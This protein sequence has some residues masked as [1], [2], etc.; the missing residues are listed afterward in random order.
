MRGTGRMGARTA[1][2]TGVSP[3]TTPAAIT[4]PSSAVKRL[5]VAEIAERCKDGRCFHYD[6]PFTNG[7]K[8]VC[9][10]SFTIE[11]INDDEP[12]AMSDEPEPTISIHALT[13]IEPR[14]GHTMKVMVIINAVALTAL[15]DSGTTHNIIDTDAATRAGLQLTPRG[16]LCVAIANGDRVSSPG[17]CRNMSISIDGEVF[18]IDCYGLALGAYNMVLGVQWLESLGSILWDI[19]RRTMAFVRHGH[20]VLW[21]TIEAPPAPPVLMAADADPLV[22]HH[23]RTAAM[24]SGSCRAPHRWPCARIDTPTS[25]SRSFSGSALRCCRQESSGRAHH[26]SQPRCC[27]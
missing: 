13:G 23:H 22:S 26:P 11:L 4:K 27:W 16:D 3:A 20:W 1:P 2:Q 6:E 10:Q 14:S 15:L 24:R 5:T 21:Q 19:D 8:L 17:S 18:I 12:L 7:H 9:K 25:R